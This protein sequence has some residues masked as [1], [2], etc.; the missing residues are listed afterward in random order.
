MTDL[1]QNMLAIAEAIAPGWER[2][3]AFIES[4]AAPVSR[5]MIDAVALSPG[6]TVLELAAGAG[7][8]GFAAALGLGENGRLISTDF[9]PAMVDIARRRGVELGI[10]NVEHAVMDA[11]RIELENDSVD[12]V[13]CRFGYMLML[14]PEKALGESKRVL[15]PGG[16]LALA[17]WGAPDRNPYFTLV[18]T[19]MVQHGHVPAPDPA[20]PGIFRLADP[21][22]IRVLLEEA[23]FADIRLDEVPVQFSVTGIEEY[24]AIIADT[25]G[26][27]GIAL[28]SIGEDER[29]TI[30]DELREPFSEFAAEPGYRLPGIVLTACAC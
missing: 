6:D 20:A 13:L 8:V 12:G 1:Q 30:R 26:P 17:V 7:D 23:G 11:E 5:W 2:R 15:R 28:R 24:L 4:T 14:D 22:H 27:L 16:R 9:S 29:S 3:R 10:A 19:A 21:S 25:A 18:G